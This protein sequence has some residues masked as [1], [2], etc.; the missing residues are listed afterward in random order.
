MRMQMSVRSFERAVVRPALAAAFTAVLL[1]PANAAAESYAYDAIG[2]MT[3]V[4]Y[5][6]GGSIHYTYDANGHILSIATSLGTTAVGG[7]PQAPLQ[8]ALGRAAPNPGWGPMA[9][10]FTIPS[11]GRAT[12]R[13]FD[14]SGRLVATLADGLFDP[15][16]YVARFSTD[17]WAGGAYFYRPTLGSR[18]L[19]RRMVLLK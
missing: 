13:V 5:D 17:R 8:F 18:V 12:L 6:N 14:A 7:G 3:T 10:P 1:A 2:R 9:I 19:S 15:G 11:R 16:P 4:T